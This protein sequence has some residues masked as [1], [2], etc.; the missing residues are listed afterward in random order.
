KSFAAQ[1]APTLQILMGGYPTLRAGGIR[2][3]PGFPCASG[4]L[5]TCRQFGAPIRGIH[6]PPIKHHRAN[7]QTRWAADPPEHGLKTDESS[8]PPHYKNRAL[9]A[10]PHRSGCVALVAVLPRACLDF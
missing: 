10:F 4:P 2:N 3:S 6:P 7:N 8:F 9:G 5:Y 1:A